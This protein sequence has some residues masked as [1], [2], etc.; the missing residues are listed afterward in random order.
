MPDSQESERLRWSTLT[1]WAIVALIAAGLIVRLVLIWRVGNASSGALTGGSDAPS[2]IIL[3]HSLAAGKGFAYVGQPTALRPPLYPLLL[4][5]L[6]LTLGANALLAM[7]M[8][9]FFI[10][11]LTAL[12]CAK[13]VSIIGGKHAQRIA[14]AIALSM[15]TLL[16]FTTQILTEALAAFLV[17]CFFYFAVREI[18]EKSRLSPLIG[19]GVSA[20]LLLLLR[21]N[22]IFIPLIMIS[23]V[24]RLPITLKD[25]KRVAIPVAISA[26]FVCPWLIRNLIVFHGGI[27]YSSQTGIVAFQGAVA[28]SGRTQ[29]EDQGH[30]REAGWWLSDI[31]TDTPRRL[32]FPSEVELNRI[33]TRAAWKAW[34]GLGLRVVPLLIK[35]VSYFWLSSDQLFDTSGFSQKQRL[36]RA[37]GVLF[38]L[39]ALA[40]AVAGFVR[41]RRRERKIANVLLLYCILATLL[42]LP[43]TMNTRLRSPLIDPLVCI[44]AALEI[45]ALQRSRKPAREALLS[46]SYTDSTAD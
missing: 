11:I 34:R 44:L 32:Q 4:S 27:L 24:L 43:A 17:S 2:Y 14:F 15:P 21:F 38:Y 46:P 12:M 18:K 36:L 26:L 35:K 6:N 1:A 39:L 40:F 30:W 29:P 16:F 19:M 41:L 9:Q 22:T 31:E 8:F 45:S 33:A 28:P 10:A 5:V 42:H 37:C 13:T 20:G 3:G 23:A 7:R 25:I